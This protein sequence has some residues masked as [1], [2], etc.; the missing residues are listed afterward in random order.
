M[1]IAENVFISVD[2]FRVGDEGDCGVSHDH[3]LIAQNASYQTYH[4]AGVHVEI[5]IYLL[6]F[7]YESDELRQFFLFAKKI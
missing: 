7:I 4:L 1:R 5:H 3:G 2:L 6:V